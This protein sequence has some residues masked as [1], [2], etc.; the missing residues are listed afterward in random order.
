MTMHFWGYMLV[1][2]SSSFISMLR[3]ISE[4]N[5]NY[6]T[7][8]ALSL[9]PPQGRKGEG[10]YRLSVREEVGLQSSSP[11]LYVFLGASMPAESRHSQASQIPAVFQGPA[12]G[13]WGLGLHI[14][15]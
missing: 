9:T 15:R 7:F 5:S 8:W 14:W 4:C 12:L 1:L 3:D 11:F 2:I 10:S 6:H 13:L